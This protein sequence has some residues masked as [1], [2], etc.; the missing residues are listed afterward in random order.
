[1]TLRRRI[2]FILYCL[3]NVANLAFGAVYLFRRQFMP[4]H[5]SAVGQPWGE[6]DGA[7][8]VLLEA[9]MDVAGAGWLA[10]F[11][12]TM[13][14][15]LTRFRRGDKMVRV[16]IPTAFLVF[17]V[18]TLLATLGVLFE[19]PSVPPWYGAAAAI[20][21]SIIA[22][23]LDAPWAGETRRRPLVTAA[24]ALLLPALVLLATLYDGIIGRAIDGHLNRLLPEPL[25]AVSPAAQAF[26][27]SLFV[28]DLHADTMMWE[29]DFLYRSEHGHVDLRRLSEGNV[30]IQVFAAVTKTVSAREAPEGADLL[31]DATRCL[32]PDSI[33]Q[34]G[35]LQ[36]AQ[37]RP[38]KT[39]FDLEARAF[40]QAARLKATIAEA[41]ARA[42]DDPEAPRMR[43]IT[44]ADDLAELVE[45]R[46]R[47]SE[48]TGRPRTIGAL[49]A[50][51]GAHWLGGDGAD[52]E[53]G[54]ARLFE[55][56]F[57]MVA[58]THRFDNA[59]ASSSEGCAP[60]AGLTPDGETFI[61]AIDDAP[62]V[63]DLAHAADATIAA[64]TGR[65]SGPVVISHTG[66]RAA[67]EALI[68][69]QEENG[70]PFCDAHRNISD[71]DIRAVARTGG[72]VGIGM[73]PEAGSRS[74]EEGLMHYAAALEALS[75]PAFVEEMRA[76]RPDYDPADH[77]AF[78]SDFDGAVHTPFDAGD[79]AILTAAL[80]AAEYGSVRLDE[81]AVRKIAGVNA[82]RIFATRLP[83]GSADRAQQI[84]APLASP[85][86]SPSAAAAPAN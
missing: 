27:D 6:L 84:C 70:K 40:D 83:G 68:Q 15:L 42:G 5:E 20:V 77:L 43:L 44:T 46:R 13:P 23:L 41:N 24:V 25:P 54:V 18:P 38:L 86:R 3:V 2:A 78:G 10:L 36:A 28:V 8:R 59:L 72:V 81:V 50:L 80:L 69:S 67:C 31:D 1:M 39:W 76:M 47:E 74:L 45:T 55:T 71:E 52:V 79:L 51:E 16:L 33:N 48:Q 57:R 14:L 26:H 37:F 22:L 82:C 53:A 63:L 62:L 11:A 7:L 34:T 66:V 58:P 60:K 9:L 12:I 32:S 19:T 21:A 56:D 65:V 73:W 75:Q 35:L 29:R 61:A 64:T 49:L 30:A 85:S 4:Y 17:Y